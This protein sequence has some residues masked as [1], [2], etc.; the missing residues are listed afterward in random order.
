MVIQPAVIAH[1]LEQ[2]IVVDVF[3]VGLQGH[4]GAPVIYAVAHQVGK[5]HDHFRG[6]LRVNGNLI[7]E[8]FQYI[9][10]K[11][12][13]KLFLQL[14]DFHDALALRQLVVVK[15]Q[16]LALNHHVAERVVEHPE[17]VENL[18]L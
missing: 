13:I 4:D 6:L 11:M 15:H 10:N 14:F 1:L 2:E 5:G 17:F 18:A 12:G 16:L 8:C 9:E 7:A 3:D